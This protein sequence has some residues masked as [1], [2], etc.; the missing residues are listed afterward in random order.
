[1]SRVVTIT[2]YKPFELGVFSSSHPGI[3]YIKKGIKRRLLSFIEQ[4]GEWVLISGQLGVELWSAEV[5]LDLQLEYPDLKLAILTPFLHQEEN[6]NE[7]NKE[8]YEFICGS[9]D[10]FDSI[11]KKKYENPS[12]FRAKNQIF[13]A[14][15]DSMII[16]YDENNEGTPQYMYKLAQKKAET[17]NY[18]IDVI[19]MDDLQ[20]IVNEDSY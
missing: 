10:F 17:G 2:G 18:P 14:K 8:F 4:G 5:V 1:M 7:E 6:W 9:A 3:D 15:S 20:E 19:T 16:V 13:M 11:S 12:Q